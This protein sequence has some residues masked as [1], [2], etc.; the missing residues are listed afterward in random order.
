M[1]GHPRLETILETDS[2]DFVI[3]VIYDDGKRI[4]LPVA[5]YSRKITPTEQNYGIEDKQLLAIVEALKEHRPLV[6]N[7]FPPLLVLTD[8]SNLTNFASK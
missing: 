1:P 7:L 3:S 6:V 8:H 4:L 2:S 5:Y